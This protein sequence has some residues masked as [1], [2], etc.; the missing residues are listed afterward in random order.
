MIELRPVEEADLHTFFEYQRDPIATR[1][2]AHRLE[3]AEFDRWAEPLRDALRRVIA[4]SVEAREAAVVVTGEESDAF[5]FV[6]VEVVALDGVLGESLELRARWRVAL[7]ERAREVQRER[8]VPE[9][10]LATLTHRYVRTEKVTG[11]APYEAWAAINCW[12]MRPT[13]RRSNGYEI[14]RADV[15]SRS[16]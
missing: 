3:Y 1:T 8:G 7:S 5:Y 2:S 9:I 4:D 10:A 15:P 6:R 14:V 11:E 12:W 16:L 13:N